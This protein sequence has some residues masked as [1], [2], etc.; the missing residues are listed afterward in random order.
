MLSYDDHI[1][2]FYLHDTA[3]TSTADMASV[4]RSLPA[5]YKKMVT[6]KKTQKFRDAV[7]IVTASTP[8]PGQGE[9]LVR[10]RFLGINASDINYT[11]GRYFPTIS[12]PFDT[13]FEGVGE[14]VAVGDQ[15][16]GISLGQVVAYMSFGAF[17][18][19]KL[20]PAQHAIP[21]PMA[22]SSPE[23]VCLLVSGLTAAIS[24]DKVGEI[25]AGEKVL[26][27]AAAGGTGQFAVQWA[28]LAGCHVI[29][30][31]S[32][33]EKAELLQTLG[34]DRPINTSK[35][36]LRAVLRKEYP[37]GVD[38]VYEAVGGSVFDACV[39]SLAKH[40]RLI[41]IGYIEGYNSDSGLAAANTATLP[42]KLLR[43]SASLRGFYLFDHASDMKTYLG[44]LIQLYMKGSLKITVDNGINH[45]KGPFKG[46]ES[47]ENAVDYL[48]SR[49][50]RGKI[51][52][53]I[54]EKPVAKM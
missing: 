31:C 49:K 2:R 45:P 30:T 38:V 48:Y 26:I 36:D 46:I 8:K 20:L 51:V 50:S 21:L 13:G 22:Q 4:R 12:P 28:K 27:T 54:P 3:F 44:K 39:N 17:S 33:D 23:P 41:I 18:E 47:I 42:S 1:Y 14:V 11:A 53:E 6:I 19:Y 16:Q 37:E 10:N 52:V 29:G 9:I 34:C 32:T 24:L 43:Q 40:G 25:K 5:A 35:E 15:C 7:Q